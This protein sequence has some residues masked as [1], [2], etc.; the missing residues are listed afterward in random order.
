MSSTSNGYVREAAKK[1]V[2]WSIRK[3]IGPTL[4]LRSR[5]LRV[6][7]AWPD[8]ERKARALTFELGR[9]GLPATLVDARSRLS[10]RLIETQRQDLWLG[11]WNLYPLQHL[12][13]RYVFYNAEPLGFG[14]WAHN[15]AWG[16]AV[17]NAID[18]WNYHPIAAPILSQTRPSVRDVPFGY[19]DYYVHE[20]RSS[21]RTLPVSTIDVLFVGGSTPRR[22]Q[23]VR[24]LQ[25]RGLNVLSVT[26]QSPLHGRDLDAAIARSRIVAS[27]FRFD[28]PR[29]HV[30]DLARL[31]YLLSNRRCVV[32]E[33]SRSSGDPAGFTQSVPCAPIEHIA[34][35]CQQLLADSGERER[36]ISR[37]SDWF[38]ETLNWKSCLPVDSLR[39]ILVGP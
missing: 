7:F 16:E 33:S 38:R 13:K 30:A 1:V 11:F 26:R 22:D 2:F 35:L 25:S 27:V 12:P 32:H 15:P 34:D 31:D 39:E 4:N 8:F 18:V 28:D 14:D 24:E 5:K 21:I 9:A 29:T 23:L 36:A 6:L 3:V 17:R 20:F 37:A 19:S 10:A